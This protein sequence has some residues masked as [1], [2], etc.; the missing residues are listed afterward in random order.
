MFDIEELDYLYAD[1]YEDLVKKLKRKIK[2]LNSEN[3][4][5]KDEKEKLKDNLIFTVLMF[6]CMMFL[7][8]LI[9][10]LWVI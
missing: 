10:F 2:Q 1:S 7:L 5:L 4:K 8:V 6:G 3:R 9:I